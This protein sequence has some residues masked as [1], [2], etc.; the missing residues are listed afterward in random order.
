MR[1]RL[2]NQT[3][4][5]EAH[6]VVDIVYLVTEIGESEDLKNVLLIFKDKA[7]QPL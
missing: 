4:D 1:D 3:W 6:S 7:S 2:N 5:E